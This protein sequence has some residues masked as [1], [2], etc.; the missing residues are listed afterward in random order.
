M[1]LEVGVADLA[2]VNAQAEHLASMAEEVTEMFASLEDPA[3]FLMHDVRFHRAIA[4]GLRQPRARRA[5]RDGGRA[6]LRAAQGDDPP[7]ARPARVGRDA[8]PHLPGH[9]R[10]RPRGSPARRWPSTC[11][12][13][14]TRRRS[15]GEAAG[16]SRARDRP[17][18]EQ[19]GAGRGS[20]LSR[21][22]GQGGGRRRRHR[23]HRPRALA[24]PGRG[25]RRRGGVRARTPRRW[26]RPRR[27]SRRE[28]AGG[29][30][31]P[32]P[33]SPTAARSRRRATRCSPRSGR[34]T[35]S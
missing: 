25:G 16:R 34:S 12:P 6:V 26:T 31:A 27:R 24:R 14:S 18:D 20:P 9:P 10:A 4:G 35:S 11:A 2:A 3:A 29:R 1:V 30:S 19:G 5:R 28:R 15:S 8:P 22:D 7:R 23:R 33:T 21:S 32:P 17:G 13:R